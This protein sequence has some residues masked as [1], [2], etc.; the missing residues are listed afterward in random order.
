VL[1]AAVDCTN[2]TQVDRPE[3]RRGAASKVEPIVR[4]ADRAIIDRA[5]SV[6]SRTRM[7]SAK[8]TTRYAHELE[9]AGRNADGLA[10]CFN[11]HIVIVT[12]MGLSPFG[13][14]CRPFTPEVARRVDDARFAL[15]GSRMT[16]R[17]PRLHSFNTNGSAICSC[18]LARDRAIFASIPTN[19][20]HDSPCA[21]LRL[22]MTLQHQS[23][24][25]A[26]HRS[27]FAPT[28]NAQQLRI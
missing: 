19:V 16:R 20:E 9:Q 1:V 26:A 4:I 15:H 6:T 27:H 14:L 12:H 3:Q 28:S 25:C 17:S 8:Y 11:R 10:A 5:S 24:G 21:P 7:R 23:A 18:S 22:P 13:I 2:R